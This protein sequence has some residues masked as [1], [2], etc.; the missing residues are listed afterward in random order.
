MNDSKACSFFTVTLAAV[1]AYPGFVEQREANREG[2]RC[3]HTTVC[4]DRGDILL[5]GS[6]QWSSTNYSLSTNLPTVY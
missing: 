5:L 2:K 6:P 1:G 3:W 4:L